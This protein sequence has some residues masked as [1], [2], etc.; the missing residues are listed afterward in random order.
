MLWT[1]RVMTNVWSVH[2]LFCLFV[3]LFSCVPCLYISSTAVSRW[4]K[5]VYTVVDLCMNIFDGWCNSPGNS[6]G[7]AAP[8]LVVLK[9]PIVDRCRSEVVQLI[10]LVDYPSMKKV[11]L[12]PTSSLQTSLERVNWCCIHIFLGQT[13]PTVDD[14]LWEELKTGFAMTVVL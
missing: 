2:V 14:T 9:S 12:V 8:T 4:I 1:A 3:R 11:H 10:G 6:P 5:D 7:A 13:V